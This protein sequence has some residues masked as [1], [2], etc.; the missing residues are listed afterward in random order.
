MEELQSKLQAK[1]SDANNN[2]LGGVDLNGNGAFVSRESRSEVPEWK[3]KL[4]EKKRQSRPE[5][6]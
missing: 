5:F 6:L 4:I 3:W 2:S 1:A